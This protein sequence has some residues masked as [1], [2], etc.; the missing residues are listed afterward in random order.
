[1]ITDLPDSH[2]QPSA[3]SPY[4]RTWESACIYFHRLDQGR[5]FAHSTHYMT[6]IIITLISCWL[7]RNTTAT[8]RSKK[9]HCP[10]MALE[11]MNAPLSLYTVWLRVNWNLR[12]LLVASALWVL[13]ISFNR[14]HGSTTFTLLR[15]HA[16][17]GSGRYL[18]HALPCQVAAH[19]LSLPFDL[20][21]FG[22][23][24]RQRP[25]AG[26]LTSRHTLLCV[27]SCF[28]E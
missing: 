27:L 8:S 5:R 14:S 12:E 16:S 15:S 25:Q 22:W 19:F 21:V 6:I 26:L 17:V 13:T 2:H 20:L 10:G 7:W 9:S 18:E 11:S 28:S 3:G 23:S 1:M 24:T 4:H